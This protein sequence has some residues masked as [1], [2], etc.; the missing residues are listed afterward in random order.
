[1][2]RIGPPAAPTYIAP[3]LINSW[4]NLGSGFQAAGYF[5]DADGIVHLAGMVTGGGNTSVFVL[6][7]GYRPLTKHRFVVLAN[8]A[9]GYVDVQAGGN[10]FFTTG[11]P[12][13]SLDGISFLAEA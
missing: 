10:V 9:L 3:T 4:A 5:K 7:A 8:G 2:P 13:V 11:S 6:P 1:M 12:W